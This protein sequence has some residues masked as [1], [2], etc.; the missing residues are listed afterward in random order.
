MFAQIKK[1]FVGEDLTHNDELFGQLAASG[2]KA[3]HQ[4]FTWTGNFKLS[5]LHSGFVHIEGNRNGID[6]ETKRILNWI[7]DNFEKAISP[8]VQNTCQNELQ[9]EVNDYALTTITSFGVG[10]N[11]VLL[12][13]TSE[14]NP[15]KNI[16]VDVIQPAHNTFEVEVRH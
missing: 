5:E 14:E 10:L 15:N 2:V 4:S 16:F 7:I 11:E 13:F 8:L 9:I 6:K 3:K 12:I 1:W